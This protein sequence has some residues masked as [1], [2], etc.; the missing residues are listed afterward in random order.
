MTITA[1]VTGDSY[2]SIW[3]YLYRTPHTIGYID[4]G[5]YRT[6]YLEAG[7]RN[8]PTVILLH[9]TAGSVENFSAN[10]AA[11]ADEFHVVAIDMA[12][13][14]WTDRVTGQMTP[15][16]WSEHVLA[17]ME[18]LNIESA[19]FVGVSLGSW[20]AVRLAQDHPG[21][22]NGIVMVA[23]VGIINDPQEYA[24]MLTE[25]LARRK[26][27]ADA[28]SWE[29]VKGVFRGLFLHE[30]EI[31]D[32]LVGI[33]LDIYR[34]P[35]MQE[36][37]LWLVIRDD[38]D[39]LKHDEWRA[40]PNPI[41]VVAAVDA[42]NIFLRNAYQIGELAPNAE[43]IELKGCDHWAQFEAAENF[44]RCSIEFLRRVS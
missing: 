29:S 33:R 18:A 44:N 14:G 35:A 43:V 11:Y 27:A 1:E 7:T 41:Q 23:P 4:A 20:V 2:R 36:S 31:L 40:L 6:R 38:S 28:P 25:I 19:S 26:K 9:G 13:C 15:K 34:D 17:A 8:Q 37:L 42:P 39:V 5:G 16:L 3:K 12:G 10:I 22:V 21:R 32:D 24:E 30:Q